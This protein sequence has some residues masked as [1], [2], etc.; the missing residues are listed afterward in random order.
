[1]H[2]EPTFW[3]RIFVSHIPVLCNLRFIDITGFNENK[4]PKRLLGVALICFI[5]LHIQFSQ[6][7]PPDIEMR[8]CS[9]KVM[10]YSHRAEILCS[11]LCTSMQ[12]PN[13]SHVLF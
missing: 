12:F 1:M 3:Q 10:Q 13:A 11:L 8:V 5:Y 9:S 4:I 6:S 2:L 7:H